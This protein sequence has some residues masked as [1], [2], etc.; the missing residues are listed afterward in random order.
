MKQKFC[1]NSYCLYSCNA[2]YHVRMSIYKTHAIKSYLILTKK[3]LRR[4]I[5]EQVLILYLT[6]FFFINNQYQMKIYTKKYIIYVK[7][8]NCTTF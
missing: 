7:P 1:Y 6:F 2:Y 4:N 8:N 3:Y 5:R